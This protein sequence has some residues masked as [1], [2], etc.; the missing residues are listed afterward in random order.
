[1]LFSISALAV[2]LTWEEC[3]AVSAEA[4]SAATLGRMDALTAEAEGVGVFGSPSFVFREP[5]R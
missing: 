3:V 5:A 2:P 4:D 1:M